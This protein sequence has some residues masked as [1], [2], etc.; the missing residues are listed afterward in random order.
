MVHR[1]EFSTVYT[2]VEKSGANFDGVPLANLI[3]PRPNDDLSKFL[4][5]FI[6]RQRSSEKFSKRKYIRQLFVLPSLTKTSR[7]YNDQTPI[8]RK[9]N[10]GY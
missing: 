3:F 10:I 4:N 1:P 9:L 6:A 2:V 8:L 7:N 5:V